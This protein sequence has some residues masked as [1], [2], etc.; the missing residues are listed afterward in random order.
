MQNR[1]R[2]TVILHTCK[3]VENF[4]CFIYT[5]ILLCAIYK[6]I[7]NVQESENVTLFGFNCLYA[8]ILRL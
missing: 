1:W 3:N 4:T 7:I 8:Y 5:E 6:A 2:L